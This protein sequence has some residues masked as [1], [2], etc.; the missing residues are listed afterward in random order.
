MIAFCEGVIDHRSHRLGGVAL[1]PERSAEPIAKL[2]SIRVRTTESA[3][4]EHIAIRKRCDKHRFFARRRSHRGNERF[5][6]RPRVG[7]WNTCS[8]LGDPAIIGQ[9]SQGLG[10]LDPWRPQQKTFAG[11][12]NV[13]GCTYRFR[14]GTE[15]FGPNFVRQGHL[16]APEKQEGEPA[17]RLPFPSPI[18]ADRFDWIPADLNMI[19]RITLPLPLP[20]VPPRRMCSP[21]LWYG[22]LRAHRPGHSVCG[23]CR[24]RHW[25]LYATW[26][27]ADVSEYCRQPL[28]DRRIA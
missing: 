15:V 8:V 26:C 19:H 9:G 17:S 3:D 2:G 20:S 11:Q 27:R 28:P 16:R 21:W 10:I 6:V 13:S 12:H 4:T 22:I 23:P 1:P 7:M 24:G 5:G 18:K 14:L 25:H